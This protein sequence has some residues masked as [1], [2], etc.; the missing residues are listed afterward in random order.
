M[1]GPREAMATLDGL[2]SSGELAA[3]C[4]RRG[5]DLL[6]VFGSALDQNAVV[7]PRDLDVAVLAPDDDTDFIGIVSELIG[8]LHCDVL[9]VMDL[10]SAGIVARSEALGR[11]Q[12]LYERRPGIFAEQQ[13]RALGQ[14]MEHGWLTDLE[15]AVL[16]TKPVAGS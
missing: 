7:A 16:A 14:R 11:G 12:P 9:D 13:M 10:G 1:A 5:I 2:A 15:L 3:W 6:V 8:L 4:E